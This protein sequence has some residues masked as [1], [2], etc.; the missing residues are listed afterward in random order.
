MTEEMM[1]SHDCHM[2]IT[3]LFTPPSPP[4]KHSKVV[5]S[6]SMIIVGTQGQLE[7]AIGH[8]SVTKTLNINRFFV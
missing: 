5:V 4:L 8:C 7:A 6:F 3:H 2:T 1:R